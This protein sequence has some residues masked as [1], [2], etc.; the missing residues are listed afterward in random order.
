MPLT[1]PQSQENSLNIVI[2][3][4]AEDFVRI[5]SRKQWLSDIHMSYFASVA[6]KVQDKVLVVNSHAYGLWKNDI[7]APFE[8]IRK[9]N[10]SYE[11]V[12]FVN[13]DVDHWNIYSFDLK[14]HKFQLYCSL[15]RKVKQEAVLVYSNIT[16]YL[17]SATLSFQETQINCLEQADGYS[18]GYFAIFFYI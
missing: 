13:H 2:D 8:E 4:F 15:K 6:N 1:P 9:R 7:Y 14:S 16:N 18:C 10:Y 3:A 12:I 11:R 5:E 17:M